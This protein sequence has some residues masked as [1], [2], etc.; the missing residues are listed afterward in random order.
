MPKPLE[1]ASPDY[2]SLMRSR[3][4]DARA[5]WSAIRQD[6]REDIRYVSG[7]PG[8]QWDPLVKQS[9]DDDG[10]PALTMDRLNPLINQ[11]VNQS[12]KD[13]PQPKI[14]PG[15][16]GDPA[17]ADVLEG[18]VRDLLYQSHAEVAFDCAEVY[19]ASGGFGFYRIT[20][21]WVGKKFIQEPRVKRIAD[22][23]TVLF[24]P[25][26]LELDYS[27]ARYC[28]IPRKY[29]RA[30]FKRTFKGEEPIPF[31]MDGEDFEDWGDERKVTV[32]EYWWVEEKPQRLLQL[33]DGREEIAADIGEWSEENPTGYRD[34]DILNEREL[35][36][37]IVHCDIVDGEKRLES[38]IW[39][40][41]WIP[42]IP[43]IGKE[44]ISD[45]K[46]RYLSAI[47]YA[48]DPQ[49]FVNASYS[50]TA[51]KMATINDAPFTGP[52]GTFK[53]KSWKDGKRHFFLEWNPVMVQGQLINPNGPQRNAFEP[54]IQAT[55]SATAQGIDA[56][57]GAVGY[58]DSVTR[59][60]QADLSGVAVER[61]DDQ[62]NLANT[63]YSDSGTESMWHCGRVLLD[64]LRALAD[65]PRA[66]DTRTAAGEEKKVP[67]TV[68]VPDGVNPHA[69][70]FEGQPHVNIDDGEYVV[71]VGPS[72][73]SK[74]EEEVEF[75]TRLVESDPALIPIYLPAIFKRRGYEDLEEIATAA[76]PPQIRMALAQAQGKAGDPALLAQQVP[77]LQQRIQQLTQV[78]QQVEQVLKTKQIETEGKLQVQNAKTQ[79]DLHVEKLKTLRALIEKTID[80][81][82][83]AT[84][85][86]SDKRHSSIDKMLQMF[87]ESEL[88]VQSA[89][90]APDPT[91]QE[92]IAA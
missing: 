78:L 17:T 42:I 71:T 85:H 1:S 20:K 2:M 76:Q 58:V 88:P 26:V 5:G 61:R 10:V 62:A 8:D 9:R 89:A 90:L 86:L 40:G 3:Y 14:G 80:N 72:Y 12:R 70:G 82:H 16:Q 25:D 57:K 45:G 51:F 19:C 7:D 43:V 60:S 81:A 44:V 53:S 67:V 87:H 66:W 74:Q 39:E 28:F 83:D 73:S 11:I 68:N 38:N 84:M 23:L 75:L 55:T 47:R 33:T 77:A 56:L 64:L 30:E 63:Q 32:A 13:R 37:R 52:T 50:S 27:D 36:E 92:P 6:F 49:I 22:P 31:P 34:E 15:D 69:P 91:T 59:P 29:D 54:A 65:T 79:G 46:R 21:E 48:R 24:D 41:Q 18:K 4:S 35:I